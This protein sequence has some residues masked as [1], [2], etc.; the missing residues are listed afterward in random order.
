MNDDMGLYFFNQRLNLFEI[1]KI[2]RMI[3]NIAGLAVRDS[4]GPLTGNVNLE[5]SLLGQLTNQM[6]TQHSIGSGNK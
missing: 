1:D 5:L 4:A 6:L 3:C 2:E